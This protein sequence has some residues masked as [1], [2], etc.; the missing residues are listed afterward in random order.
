MHLR[1][2]LKINAHWDA[3]VTFHISPRL[4]WHG[5]TGQ[6]AHSVCA[7]HEASPSPDLWVDIVDRKGETNVLAI[8]VPAAPGIA[9][10]AGARS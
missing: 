7:R 2:A 3:G 8:L 4:K 1:R 10:V 9:T 6:R 5:W